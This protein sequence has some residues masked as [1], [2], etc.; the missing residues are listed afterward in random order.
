[1]NKS[2]F[3]DK[4]KNLISVKNQITDNEQE[5]K[6]ITINLQQAKAGDIVFYKLNP[7]TGLAD[8]EKR[9]KGVNPSLIVLNFGAEKVV[10]HDN[11][12]FIDE[13]KFLQAQKIILD[14]LFPNNNKMKLVGITGTN[15]KT[16]SV[17]LS[18]Q[19]STMLGHKAISVGTIGV[20][21]VKGEVYPEFGTTTPSYVDIR[22]IINKFQNEYEACFMEV[23]SHSLV[24][25]RLNEL[26]L[27]AGAWT[28]FS[29]DHLDYHQTMEEY[30]NAKML[31]EKVYLKES[32]SLI[33]PNFEA[34]MTE[35][36]LSVNPNTRIKVAKTLGARKME[37]LPL[38]YRSK[39]NQSNLEI[40][41]EINEMLWGD[42]KNI[43]VSK[44]ETP[45]GRFSIIELGD[46]S[47]VIVD[48]AHT[49]DALTNIGNAIK[50]AF[51]SHKVTVIFGCGG[52]RDKTKRPKMAKAVSAFA[53]KMIITSDNPRNE[54]PE[55]IILDIIKNASFGYEAIVDRKKAIICAL[56]ECEENEIILIAGKG[57]EEYQEINGV[58]HDFSDFKVVE[59]Y[60]EENS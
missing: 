29:Q 50:E 49:P 60:I 39:Y 56:E 18:M 38:F 19:I 16:T 6:D 52:N 27:D 4:L 7:T 37:S 53:D 47:M 48:Y 14:E 22:K 57:H 36:I 55:D 1:M 17:N 8:F 40:S 34:A 45:K 12:I 15:G 41:L 44:M 30:L 24:Q 20:F 33:V 28:S 26:R 3:L 23:S 2:Q 13:E 35:K 58:K 54:A 46:E 59:D 51:P 43:D 42:L 25:N 10:K 9:F 32:A 21:D 11:C 31:L 5:I